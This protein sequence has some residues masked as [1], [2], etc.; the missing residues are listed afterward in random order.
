M[1]INNTIVE[2][3]DDVLFDRGISSADLKVR[4]ISASRVLGQ[5]KKALEIAESSGQDA[6]AKQL[7]NKI[8]LLQD[9]VDHADE[10]PGDDDVADG[11]AGADDGETVDEPKTSGDSDEDSDDTDE[12]N[13]GDTDDASNEDSDDEDEEDEDEEDSEDEIEDETT[14]GSDEESDSEEDD[15]ED[16]SEESSEE[17]TETDSET[18]GP[19]DNSSAVDSDEDDGDTSDS[20]SDPEEDADEEAEE[21]PDEETD[22]GS[23]DGTEGDTGDDKDT[24]SSGGSDGDSGDEMSDGDEG[25]EPDDPDEVLIDPFSKPPFGA[26]SPPDI[27]PSKI[28]SVFKAAKRILGKLDGEAKRGAAAGLKKL[29]SGRG[30]PVEESL[31][32]AVRK[33]LARVPEDEFNDELAATMDLVDKII[34][35]DYSDDL[36][37]RVAEIKSDAASSLSRMELEKEDAEHTKAERELARSAV[38]ASEKENEKYAKV[39]GLSGLDAFKATLYRAVKDQVDEAEDEIETWAAL[40]RRHEDDPSIIVKGKAL[41]DLDSD[42]PSI[43]VYFDQSGSWSNADIEK[44]I[45]AISVINEFHERKEIK[46]NIYYMS[47]GGIFTSA[48]AARA[49]GGAEG[50]ADAL[51]HIRSTKVKNVIILSDDDLDSYEWSNRPTGDNGRTII[52][53]C[54]WWLWKDAEVSTKALKEL[55]GRRGNFQYQFEGSRGW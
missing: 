16:D 3:A 53:G 7:R 31:Q 50:W 42:I 13:D 17:D 49:H 24:G 36:D 43:N 6:I 26:G 52:D 29:L 18:D 2:A 33:H 5:A 37:A 21:E 10:D 51:K 9:W 23:G 28:E 44:G 8:D 1:Q 32:E 39:K 46:L 55:M 4:K 41:D 54:V 48:S 38:R 14:E 25:G 35:V 40:D 15:S 11:G 27:D 12:E 19:E 45:R 22:A 47:A 30:I 34:K 20:K